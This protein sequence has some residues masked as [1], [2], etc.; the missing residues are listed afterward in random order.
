MYGQSTSRLL[1]D[2]LPYKGMPEDFS[3]GGV[4]N[5]SVALASDSSLE[6]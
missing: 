6:R 2:V 3:M 4:G 5:F 1:K